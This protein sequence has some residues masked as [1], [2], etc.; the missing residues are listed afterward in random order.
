VSY[1]RPAQ[2]IKNN[3]TDGLEKEG[4]GTG[5]QQGSDTRGQK[6]E[7]SRYPPG[8]QIKKLDSQSSACPEA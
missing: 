8:S 2:R 3:D 1:L 4:N 5:K 6:A 7:A